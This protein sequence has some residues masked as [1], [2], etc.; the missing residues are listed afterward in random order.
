MRQKSKW[1]HLAEQASEEVD[2]AKLAVLVADLCRAI[3]G[4]RQDKSRHHMTNEPE[5]I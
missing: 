5:A 3:N 1:L 2:P 4:E